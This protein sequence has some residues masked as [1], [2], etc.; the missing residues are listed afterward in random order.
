MYFAY[1]L[2]GLYDTNDPQDMARL[3]HDKW[4]ERNRQNQSGSIAGSS[5]VKSVT[6]PLCDIV[7]GEVSRRSE[8]TIA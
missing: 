4:K 6:R 7:T 1:Y 2:G 8:S 3:H 5:G